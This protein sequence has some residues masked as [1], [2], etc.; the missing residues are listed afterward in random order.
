MTSTRSPAPPFKVPLTDASGQVSRAW[1]A[2]IQALYE[3]SGGSIDKVDAAHT[4]ALAAAP[5]SARVF[6]V[7]GLHAGGDLSGDVAVAL[8]RAV[9][10]VASLPTA[11]VADGDWAYAVDGRKAGEAAGAGTGVPVWW[12][13]GR[14]FAVD[15]G[16]VVAT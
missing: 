16:A 1:Q 3:R 4:A 9:G 15:S 13:G 2:F 14:W 8:Y 11:G 7:G 5:R 6:G 10:T 12:S